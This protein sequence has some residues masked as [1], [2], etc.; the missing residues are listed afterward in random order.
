M[1]KDHSA[2]RSLPNELRDAFGIS[3]CTKTEMSDL[4]VGNTSSGCERQRVR[5]SKE[6]EMSRKEGRTKKQGRWKK[7]LRNT[8][9]QSKK[10]SVHFMLS[11]FRNV[12]NSQ[13]RNT[14]KA[15][16]MKQTPAFIIYLF[17][18]LEFSRLE[19]FAC[20]FQWS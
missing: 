12:K 16:I 15:K 5:S 8:E 17:S 7:H 3:V 18:L 10:G 2:R 4:I 11:F 13:S 14:Q 9:N 6:E 20:Q 1:Y 19:Q